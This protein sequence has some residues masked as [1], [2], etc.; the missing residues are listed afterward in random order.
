MNEKPTPRRGAKRET[1]TQKADRVK[2]D[3][4]EAVAKRAVPV[5]KKEIVDARARQRARDRAG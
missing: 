4:S 2:H 1:P 5:R 3:K